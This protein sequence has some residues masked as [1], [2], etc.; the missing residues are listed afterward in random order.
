MGSS[1]SLRCAIDDLN[2]IPSCERQRKRV[3]TEREQHLRAEQR[4]ERLTAEDLRLVT[5]LVFAHFGNR[6]DQRMV[7]RHRRHAEQRSEQ[8]MSLARTA[9][10][11][12]FDDGLIERRIA[13]R[14]SPPAWSR[15]D[16]ARSSKCSRRQSLARADR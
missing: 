6:G 10:R 16:R 9:P 2:A 8:S 7:L 11:G 4:E 13:D 15:S 12:M 3:G 5:E 14:A 1:F